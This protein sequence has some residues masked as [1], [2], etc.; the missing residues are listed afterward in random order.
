MKK[1]VYILGGGIT[2]LASAYELLKHGHNVEIIEKTSMIGGLAIS[3]LLEFQDQKM[4]MIKIIYINLEEILR[5]IKEMI[6]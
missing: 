2:G 6:F 4:Y 5:S 3:D 1:T